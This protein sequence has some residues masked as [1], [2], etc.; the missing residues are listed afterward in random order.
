MPAGLG[1]ISEDER[2]VPVVLCHALRSVGRTRSPFQPRITIR[3]RTAHPLYATIRD[4]TLDNS[5]ALRPAHHFS[6]STWTLYTQTIGA[7]LIC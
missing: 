3:L 7:D 1:I 6:S 5:L 2:T 4:Q